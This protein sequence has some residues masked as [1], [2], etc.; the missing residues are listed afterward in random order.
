MSDIEQTDP[1]VE[2]FKQGVVFAYPTEAVFGL[3]CDPDNEEAVYRLLSLKKRPVE[4][5]M[6]LVA[7]NYSQLLPYVNDSAIPMD[8]RSEIFSSWPGPVTW[9]LPA[10]KSAPDWVT[11]GS[12]LIAVRVS[13]HPVVQALCEKFSKPLVS[14]SANVSGEE[15]AKNVGQVKAQFDDSVVCIEG[16]LGDS[17]KPTTIK[18]GLNGETLRAS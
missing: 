15:P 3:G 5:G 6:I 1:L 12:E 4:K 16:A 10:S 14:T 8:R 18:N 9:L 11:G 13:A 2:A 17:A 7:K